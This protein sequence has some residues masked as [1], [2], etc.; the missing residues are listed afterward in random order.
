MGGL[1]IFLVSDGWSYGFS[2]VI[3]YIN[4][5]YFFDFIYFFLLQVDIKFFKVVFKYYKLSGFEFKWFRKL[6]LGVGDCIMFLNYCLM[7]RVWD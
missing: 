3:F 7:C 5:K 4:I 6:I 2:I 1:G